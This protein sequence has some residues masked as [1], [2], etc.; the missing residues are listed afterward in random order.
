MPVE[1]GLVEVLY[2]D[3]DLMNRKRCGDRGERT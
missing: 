2:D 1:L 3:G